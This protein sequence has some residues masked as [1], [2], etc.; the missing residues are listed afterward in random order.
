MAAKADLSSADYEKLAEGTK[1]FTVDEALAAFQDGDH[2]DVAPEHGPPDQ[3][4][5]RGVWPDA[6]E[7]FARRASSCPSSRRST[8]IRLRLRSVATARN[9]NPSSPPIRIRPGASPWPTRP[10]RP[11]AV[12]RRQAR[13]GT[14]R[15]QGALL[16]LRA[17]I[18]LSAT[19]GA[20]VRR[21]CRPVRAV[22][23]RGD[24]LVDQHRPR[25]EPVRRLERG[26]DYW[27]SGELGTDF[28]AQSRHACSRRTR[29]AWASASC[30]VSRSGASDRS[31][32]SGSRPSG[33]C[34]T[35]RPPRS[36]RCSCS[37]SASTSPP[38]IALIIVGTVFYN[39][40]MIADVARA[41]P[42]S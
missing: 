34:A 9:W 42:A 6:E 2:V 7:G 20:R 30:S 16:R 19:R 24:V 25:P 5:P 23:V 14:R 37:G 29:S 28:M 39:I 22:V 36:R 41:C 15:R 21:C 38:K 33:S 12:A 10:S 35:S 40:L 31:S 11:G 3:P 18:P 8:R 17:E 27:N 26:V 32:R 4:V 1:L 13:E